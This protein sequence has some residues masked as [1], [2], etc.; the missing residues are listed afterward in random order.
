MNDDQ[1]KRAIEDAL[2]VDPSPHFVAR[3]RSHVAKEGR[4]RPAAL[5]SIIPVLGV[6][7]A[8]LIAAVVLLQPRE[9]IS[10]KIVDTIRPPR[11]ETP[12]VPV[13]VPQPVPPKPRKAPPKARPSSDLPEVLIDP[14]EAAAFRNLLER[15]E[16]Q[17]I[18]PEMLNE[19]AKAAERAEAAEQII[20]MPIAAIEPIAI[21]P[22]NSSVS[23]KEGGSL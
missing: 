16:E 13:E 3:V 22:L 19:F 4:R 21:S 20:P 11:I 15:I 17:K 7:T 2:A 10:P 8:V 18:D 5:S 6:A 14:R 1:L 12:Q 23:V 9:T